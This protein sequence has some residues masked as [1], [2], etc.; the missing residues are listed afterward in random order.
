MFVVLIYEFLAPKHVIYR[1]FAQVTEGGAGG[2]HGASGGRGG[3]CI[4]VHL[5]AWYKPVGPFMFVVL[6]ISV[7]VL[8]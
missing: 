3:L 4:S 6:I 5:R 8:K 7:V 1:V 2:V